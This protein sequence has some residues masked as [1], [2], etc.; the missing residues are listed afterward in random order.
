M[1][2]PGYVA[3]DA[4][5]ATKQALPVRDVPQAIEVRTRQVLDD[6]GGKATSYDVA[7]TVAGVLNVDDGY[8]DPGRNVPN[9]VFRGYPNNGV[10]LKDGHAVNGWMS[11]VDMAGVERVEF[12]KGP[13][14]VLYGGSTYAGDIGGVVNYVSKT[15]GPDAMAAG[16]LTGGSFGFARLTGDAGAGLG[17]GRAL[18]VRLNGAL[19]R[20]DSWRQ[21]ARHDTQYIAPAIAWHPTES[22]SILLLG[23]AAWASEV[24]E[25]G[26]PFDPEALNIPASRNFIDPDYD[27]TE[28]QAQ[29]L[30]LRYAHAFGPAW[31]LAADVSA[32]RSR[33]DQHGSSLTFVP[34]GGSTQDGYRWKLRND[35]LEIDARLEGRFATGP[36][37]HAL[38]LGYDHQRN[39]YGADSD[40]GWGGP[41]LDVPGATLGELQW[42]PPGSMAAAAAT[43]PLDLGS[44]RWNADVDAAYA[45]DLVAVIPGLKL[46]LGARLDRFRQEYVYTGSFAYD[47]PDVSDH[48][49]SPRAGVVWQPASSASLYAVYSEAF[50]PN[51]GLTL[52]GSRPPPDVGRLAEVGLKVSPS[53]RLQANVAVYRLE[54]RNMAFTDPADPSG[55]AILVAGL[56]RSQGVE[57]D[58]SGRLTAGL[59][60]IVNAS[61]MRG[62]IVEGEPGGSLPVGKDFAGVPRGTLG[63][64][65]VQGFGPGRAFELGGGLY[66][67]TKAW[68]DPGNT[69]RLPSLVQVD[70]L[71]AWRISSHFRLQV[72]ARNLLDRRNYTSNGW[73]WITPSE[74]FSAFATIR[75]EL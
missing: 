66:V 53:D 70:A 40:F 74:P 13:A 32:N 3:H 18:Q 45:Q 42:P 75:A 23:D 65:A 25:H 73:L 28:I 30:A 59:R 15:P 14:A 7:R 51:V 52:D 22:D 21:Y 9:F 6:L 64:L 49:V 43:A 54:R 8:G 41:S 17:E 5:T 1:S 37:G 44:F 31:R 4:S 2:E 26:F 24:P 16:D 71:G 67:T 39:R 58:V 55:N 46:L 27:R 61:L 19:E 48:H 60:A 38:L 56:T 33:T 12:L 29:S 36:L 34:G 47:V 20:G 35:Q 11:T 50:S 57:V 62:W 63:I 72:N 68:A 10:Y 69:L